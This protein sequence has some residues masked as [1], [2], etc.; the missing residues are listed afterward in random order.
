MYSLV[1]GN[2]FY[3]SCEKIFRPDWQR[4]PVVVL[5]NN[6]GCVVARCKIAKEAGVPDLVP[7]FQV[8]AQLKRINAVVCSSNYELYGD[9]SQRM[10]T[11]LGRHCGRVEIYSIDE[12]FLQLPSTTTDYN[13]FGKHIKEDVFQCVRMPVCVGTAPTKTLAK[14]ANRVAKKMPRLDGV[15]T[16]D[17]PEKWEWVLKR[18]KTGD[19][20]GIGRRIST[21]LAEMG[22][23]TALELAQSNPKDI[24][25]KFSVVVERTLRELN[26]EACIPL[27]EDPEP[28][29]EIICSR[30][31]SKKIYDSYELQEAIATYAANAC[32]KL[33]AQ[34]SLTATL[35]VYVLSNRFSGNYYQNQHT[36][37]LDHYTNDTITIA[38]AA[39]KAAAGMFRP[40]TPFHKC[41]IALL[42]LR[43]HTPEQLNVF[44]E[45]QSEKSRTLMS[46]LDSIN[47]KFGRGSLALAS[48]GIDPDWAM[49]RKMQSPCYTTRWSDIPV[50]KC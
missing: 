19:V 36:I 28:K 3:A 12:A 21:R 15:C 20:W 14:L 9:I 10:M 42:D 49:I 41:G 30:S 31:F 5:S 18:T 8:K 46:T 11:T 27:E 6:D 16:L 35:Q 29:K 44:G 24:R 39:R 2:S 47:K 4:R 43:E 22:I 40:D 50:V 48:Q 23:H 32:E 25:R 34:G 38:S 37:K 33:R 17:T 13:A 1:D 45:H 26:G 7:Y